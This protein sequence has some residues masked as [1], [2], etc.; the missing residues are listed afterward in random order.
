[1]SFSH[2]EESGYYDCRVTGRDDIY[3]QFHVIVNEN[4]ESN[5]NCSNE[6]SFS[7]N[8]TT[9]D[10]PTTTTSVSPELVQLELLERLEKYL[11]GEGVTTSNSK[12]VC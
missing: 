1:M 3:Y 10:V 6:N 7:I 11:S 9:I 12:G 8:P 2:I 4:C 5:E